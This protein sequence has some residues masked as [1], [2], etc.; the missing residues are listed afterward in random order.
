[1]ARIS[2][3]RRCAWPASHRPAGPPRPSPG[4]P[5]A[6]PAARPRPRPRRRPRWRA[7]ATWPAPRARR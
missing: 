3:A 6:R 2:I 4:P 7:A 1:M 5:G